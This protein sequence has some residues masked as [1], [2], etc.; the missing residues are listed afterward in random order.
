MFGAKT[1][2]AI[3]MQEVVNDSHARQGEVIDDLRKRLFEAN[4]T[5][6]FRRSAKE[7]L[8]Q[9]VGEI[10]DEVDG[11]KPIR[12]SDPNNTELRNSFYVDTMAEKVKKHA[13]G[14]PPAPDGSRIAMDKETIADFKAKR[15]IK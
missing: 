15:Q 8:G 3:A 4:K 7:A 5:K 11:R 9:L 1:L 14:L 2:Q 13:A 12:L 6:V 10:I